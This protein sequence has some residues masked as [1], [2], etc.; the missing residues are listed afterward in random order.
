MFL[1]VGQEIEA[2]IMEINLEN[3]KISL[4][5]KEVSSYR[6]SKQGKG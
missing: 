2:K 5:I 4:S 1:Q 3:K 6:S